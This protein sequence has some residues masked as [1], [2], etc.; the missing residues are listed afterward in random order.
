M[1]IEPVSLDHSKVAQLLCRTLHR[2]LTYGFND[3]Q[4]IS[5]VELQ[6]HTP[7]T[8]TNLEIWKHDE[9]EALVIAGAIKNTVQFTSSITIPVIHL[10][11]ILSYLTE[12]RGQLKPLP[13]LP[14]VKPSKKQMAKMLAT[15]GHTYSKVC[16]PGWID[17]VYNLFYC[18]SAII[19]TDYSLYSVDLTSKL[20]DA[21]VADQLE[22][23]MLDRGFDYTDLY[24]LFP[25]E[26]TVD[27]DGERHSQ[28]VMLRGSQG[29]HEILKSVGILLTSTIREDLRQAIGQGFIKLATMYDNA[30]RRRKYSGLLLLEQ[31]VKA[32]EIY[33]MNLHKGIS[34]VCQYLLEDP[35]AGPEVLVRI[36]KS[37]RP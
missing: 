30:P 25:S 15:T 28:G 26:V 37:I 1:A 8:A 34:K 24:S 27:S 20:A 12:I 4:Y 19:N 13:S 3:L 29:G 14:F 11:K 7:P 2:C 18:D 32:P 10:D 35:D 21:S 9:V 33:V 36:R 31:L 6:N 17:G 5:Y 22:A 23:F 16:C